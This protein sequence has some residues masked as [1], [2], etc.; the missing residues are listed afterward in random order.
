M[1]DIPN[2]PP[3]SLSTRGRFVLL[4]VAC[5]TIM[6]GTV[7]APGLAIISSALGVSAHASWLITLPALGVI[8]F[9]PLAGRLIDHIGPYSAL[10]MGLVSYG[11]LGVAGAMLQSPV[12]VFAD[13]VLLGGATA[14]VMVSGTS[15]ISHWYQGQER[16]KML[17]HQGMAIEL[18]GVLFLLTAGVLA[19]IG[20]YWPFA[21]Y[22]LAWVMLLML[23]AWV[24]SRA[25]SDKEAGVAADAASGAGMGRVYLAALAAMM[26]FF[27]PIVLIPLE[28]S[29]MGLREAE[30]GFFLAAIALVAVATAMMLPRIVGLI[31]ENMT[32]P[33]AFASF[34]ASLTLFGMAEGIRIM[35]FGALFSGIGFGLSIPLVNHMTVERTPT[36]RR[37]RNLAYLSMA[38]FSGQ[39]LTSLLEFLPRQA[40]LVFIVMA[41]VGS[42]FTLVYLLIWLQERV[43]N[44]IAAST[45]PRRKA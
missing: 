44:D 25:P 38:I 9:A 26:L 39:F 3:A 23:R 42:A 32:L 11:L 31:G 14:V 28:L 4:A 8:L 10:Q 12:L 45:K 37:G 27:T 30:I 21:I 2:T 15:L 33:L 24:P 41:G 17:A 20:W 40:A 35:S 34:T 16:L 5:L 22:F 7:V 6:V 19:E 43:G 13:R 18:G 1:V 29:S 36:E